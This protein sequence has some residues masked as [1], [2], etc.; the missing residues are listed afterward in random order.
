MV[1]FKLCIT[2][3]HSMIVCVG[4]KMLPFMVSAPTVIRVEPVVYHI[5]YWC[6]LLRC[7]LFCQGVIFSLLTWKSS[8]FLFSYCLAPNKY[9]SGEDCRVK[10]AHLPVSLNQ[11]APLFAP[12]VSWLLFTHVCWVTRRKYPGILLGIKKGKLAD[13]QYIFWAQLT[14]DTQPRHNS[15]CW[16]LNGYSMSRLM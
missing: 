9:L 3:P 13:H 14:H 5:P 8:D 7:C 12:R 4:D 16:W 15:R 1:I 6:P 10:S 11:I 2:F